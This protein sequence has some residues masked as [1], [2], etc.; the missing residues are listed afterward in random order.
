MGWLMSV[1]SNPL[2]FKQDDHFPH[3]KNKNR[4]TE[5]NRKNVTKNG[6]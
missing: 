6:K 5:K 4:K 1:A 3:N 2:K